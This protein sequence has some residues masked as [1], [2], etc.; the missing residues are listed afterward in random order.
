MSINLLDLFVVAHQVDSAQ[1]LED[2]RTMEED[3]FYNL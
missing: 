1:Q 2:L 3:M